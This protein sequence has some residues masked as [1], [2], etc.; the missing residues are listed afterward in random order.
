LHFSIA[1]RDCFIDL[2]RFSNF[3]RWF[4][5]TFSEGTNDAALR[6]MESGARR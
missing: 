3:H 5:W 1:A 4:V 2:L 6:T